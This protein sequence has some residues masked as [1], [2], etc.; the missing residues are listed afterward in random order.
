MRGGHTFHWLMHNISDEI[1][2]YRMPPP[3]E[4][5]FH[6]SLKINSLQI[7]TINESPMRGEYI[8]N[9]CVERG[10]DSYPLPATFSADVE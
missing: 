10:R 3:H 8:K 5:K 1:T 4:P 7:E 9:N 6:V 2:I